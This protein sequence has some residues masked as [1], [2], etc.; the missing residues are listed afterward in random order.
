MT[1]FSYTGS[2]Q[3]GTEV[4]FI[5]NLSFFTYHIYLCRYALLTFTLNK[6]MV[7]LLVHI[8]H[9]TLLVREI[10]KKKNTYFRA[11]LWGIENN[12]KVL[13]SSRLGIQIPKIVL[14]RN[15]VSILR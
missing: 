14:I 3:F 1:L 5:A 6:H 9:E 12:Y 15:V 7:H 4:A 8:G 2:F 10:L 13:I 11:R